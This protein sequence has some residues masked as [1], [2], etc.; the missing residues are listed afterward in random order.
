MFDKFEALKR[1]NIADFVFIPKRYELWDRGNL[2]KSG[3][4]VNPIT[5]KVIGTQVEVKLSDSSLNSEI[6]SIHTYDMC[7]TQLDRV[8][9]ILVPAK[10]NLTTNGIAGLQMVFGSTRQS[11]EFEYNEPY[12]CNLFFIGGKL[13]KITF[14]LGDPDRLI[15]FYG[16]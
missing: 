8:Q 1:V 7:V 11:K 5:G 13:A 2:R 12:C 16:E 3:E 4:T 10:T 6:S 9:L 14:S 15:E